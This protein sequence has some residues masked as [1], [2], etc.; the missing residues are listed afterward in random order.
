[1]PKTA[2]NEAATAALTD[3]IVAVHNLAPA[4]TFS[5][6][7][8]EKLSVLQTLATIFSTK[9]E[10]K[11]PELPKFPAKTYLPPANPDPARPTS[12]ETPKEPR[13]ATTYSE[14]TRNP[15]QRSCQTEKYKK[16]PS[17]VK[18]LQTPA[19][20]THTQWMKI[21]TPKCAAQSNKGNRSSN[22]AV[23]S[24]LPPPLWS[25]DHANSLNRPRAPKIEERLPIANA[26][27]HPVIGADHQRSSYRQ[28]LEP[29]QH[30]RN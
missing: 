24:D 12:V 1:M 5:G 11:T 28:K 13:T 16:H 23:T 4:G 3:L 26:V 8:T 19:V 14:M 30:E 6:I 17:T 2:S 29:K 15:G 10:D 9:S 21:G 27:L 22:Y 18:K 25:N 7:D 20:A